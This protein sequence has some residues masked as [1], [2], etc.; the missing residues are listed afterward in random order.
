MLTVA[1]SVAG[2]TWLLR[3]AIGNVEGALKVHAIEEESK[4]E[5]LTG[6]VVKLERKRR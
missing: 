3:S 5:A 6:R 2:A 4:R 1:G